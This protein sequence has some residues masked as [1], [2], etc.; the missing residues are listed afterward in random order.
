M[1]RTSERLFSP[2]SDRFTVELKKKKLHIT[3]IKRRLHFSAV[4]GSTVK[5][6]RKW[7]AVIGCPTQDSTAKRFTDSSATTK[8]AKFSPLKVISSWVSFRH[9]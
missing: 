5:F 2:S 8:F 9:E 7:I 6:V 3:I 1:L 4:A